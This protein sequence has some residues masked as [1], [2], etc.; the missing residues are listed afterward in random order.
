[1]LSVNFDDDDDKAWRLFEIILFWN[2]FILGDSSGK[3]GFLFW[4]PRPHIYKEAI[5]RQTD[6]WQCRVIMVGFNLRLLWLVARGTDS[7][8]LGTNDSAKNK[9]SDTWLRQFSFQLVVALPSNTT[10][11]LKYSIDL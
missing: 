9:I 7:A 2:Y 5:R 11:M 6:E 10:R 8:E 4:K 3:I 1:M